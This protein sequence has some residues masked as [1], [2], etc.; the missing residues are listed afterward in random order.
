MS[1]EVVFSLIKENSIE[2]FFLF[3]VSQ[4]ETNVKINIPVV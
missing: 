3:V 4:H 1:A 2:K